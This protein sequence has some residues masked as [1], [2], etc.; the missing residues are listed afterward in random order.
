MLRRP[1]TIA[2]IVIA[3]TTSAPHG[4]GA[5]S[6]SP[7]SL[8]TLTSAVM[9]MRS[10][11]LPSSIINTAT[12][13]SANARTGGGSVASALLATIPL[14][15]IITIA[16]HRARM[17]DRLSV[18]TAGTHLSKETAA[19][20]VCDTCFQHLIKSVPHAAGQRLRPPRNPA[21]DCHAALATSHGIVS[22]IST[23]TYTNTFTKPNKPLDGHSVSGK[24][25]SSSLAPSAARRT[26]GVLAM[27]RRPRP[28]TV[29]AR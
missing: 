23:I 8:H 4:L 13:G 29:E 25:T 17:T 18:P 26:G 3:V 6:T 11:G 22:L 20:A 24:L 28:C 10:A 21:R 2:A 14:M 12:T 16:T 7:S 27:D 9:A 1:R 15:L 5:A 19:L